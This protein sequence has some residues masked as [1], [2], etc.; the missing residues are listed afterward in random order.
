[1]SDSVDD[2][3]KSTT[4][5]SNTIP[6]ILKLSASRELAAAFII[7]VLSLLYFSHN[8]D[9]RPF[10]TRGEGREAIVVKAMI[11][12]S[13]FVLPL[14]NG[15]DIPSKPPMF[16]WLA[17][18]ASFVAGGLSE[19]TVRLPSALTA[20]CTVV[21][22]F[23]FCLKFGGIRLGMLSCLLLV[24][25]FEF[26][27]GAT[28]ARVDM[29]FSTFVVA[30]LFLLYTI[31]EKY[32][33]GER[34]FF[35]Q[36]V[37]LVF[38]LASAVLSKGPVGV[39]AS[40]AILLIYHFYRCGFRLKN[41]LAEVPY[42]WL[43]STASVAILLSAI[44]YLLAYREHGLIF[45]QTQI[46]NENVARVF[47]GGQ[48]HRKSIFVAP[49]YCL[50]VFLPW[51]L[52]LPFFPWAFSPSEKISRR[53]SPYFFALSVILIFLTLVCLSD[54][55]RMV[56]FLPC[57]PFF[58]MILA[59]GF[60]R[61]DKEELEYQRS[62]R[63]GYRLLSLF[64]LIAWILAL[65]LAAIVQSPDI[66]DRLVILISD[67]LFNDDWANRVFDGLEFVRKLGDLVF[68]TFLIVLGVGLATLF[69]KR[70][71]IV[72]GAYL[73]AIC[74]LAIHSFIDVYVLPP[75]VA[76]K[77]PRP[78]MS[79]VQRYVSASELPIYEL[80]SRWYST[81]FYFDRDITHVA[82]LERLSG[83][84][85]AFY[86]VNEKDVQ[87]LLFRYPNSFLI[88]TKSINKVGNGRHVLV[89]LEQVADLAVAETGL[90]KTTEEAQDGA[91]STDAGK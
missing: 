54:S 61:C 12:Q 89:L 44:W 75:I 17:S 81:R 50:A 23:L 32:R 14:R 38:I 67:L 20:S 29:T 70:K 77:D 30:S 33:C 57:L 49:L 86:I 24:S 13:N 5:A 45:L 71:R 62:I 78:F 7:F 84:E 83:K 90:E 39:L 46:W 82:S 59:A 2:R 37:L 28:H 34:V 1:M 41:F 85:R 43:I 16:H 63:F 25:S 55:K 26:L 76:S 68:L 79:V 19:F 10:W 73:F 56:Y 87:A 65:C 53:G 47:V 72:L 8:L 60:L 27:R 4:E 35:G 36:N 42:L 9:S 91:E 11:E 64:A 58:S 66:V 6:F 48:G 31:Y 40:I 52:F 74:V 21:M 18:A 15:S 3:S 22:T 51:A 80:K 69:F 88:L